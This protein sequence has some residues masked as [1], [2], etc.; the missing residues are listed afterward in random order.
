MSDSQSSAEG[1]STD[2]PCD[3]QVVTDESRNLS[4]LSLFQVTLRFSWIFK[5]ESVLIP[6]FMD[7]IDGSGFVRGFCPF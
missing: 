5:T 6:R 1:S 7:V 3:S 2:R 4:V